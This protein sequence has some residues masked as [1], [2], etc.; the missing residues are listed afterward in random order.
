M[1]KNRP[2]SEKLFEIA[3]SQ[4]GYFTYKQALS[5]GYYRDAAHFYTK[6]GEWLREKRGIYRLAR[7]PASDRP[8]LVLWS[9]WSTDRGGK[10]QGVYSYQ[11]ALSL[12]AITDANPAKLHITV[13]PKF[14][15]FN[16]P[17]KGIVFHHAELK[18]GEINKQQGYFVTTPLKTLQDM[19]S[20]QLMDANEAK[21]AAKQAVQ[22]GIMTP[23]EADKV[24]SL[25]ND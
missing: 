8:D 17:P 5:A 10:V 6:S 23:D 7:F 14:R 21:L 25:K 13:P 15:K 16:S 24:S 19:F 3:E 20:A 9:L 12:Y 4:Q 1:S 11:T 22:L 18:E 2:A